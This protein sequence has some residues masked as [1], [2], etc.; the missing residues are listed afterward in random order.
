MCSTPF[1]P[2]EAVSHG[3]MPEGYAGTGST[4]K[5]HRHLVPLSHDHHHALVEAR[6]LRRAADRVDA[7]RRAAV[8]AF[9]RFFSTET[10]RHFREE[11]EQL[12]PAL[13]D[14]DGADGDLLVQAL[15]EHQRIHALVRRL[16]HGVAAGESDASSMRE[17]AELLEAH[18]RLEERQLF[19]LIE[20]VVPEEA[21]GELDRATSREAA[22]SAVDLLTPRGTGPLW[23]TETDDLN[24][25]LLAWPTGGGTGEHVNSERDVVLVVVA[26]SAT[27][28]IDGEPHAVH[29]GEALIL[30]KG[31][32]RS[33]SAGPDGVRYL[34]VH[35]RRAP[36]QIT[37]RSAP[38][39]NGQP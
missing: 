14:H 16:E 4:M 23:G 28:A 31:R 9:L 1:A 2:L 18:V 13:V 39:A 5:R 22:A 37:P 10:I 25:T 27:V 12:F 33:I 38:P 32:R 3:L 7:D 15:L 30:E 20:Q 21:L 34:S 19:P 6:R 29:A 36:L 17:L 24:A 8:T 35:R 26:G 11:E